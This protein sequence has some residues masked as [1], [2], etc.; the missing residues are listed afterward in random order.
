[1]LRA[2]SDAASTPE[3][4]AR[5]LNQVA[6]LRLAGWA[7][8][9][10]RLAVTAA[11]CS[12]RMSRRRVVRPTRPLPPCRHLRFVSHRRCRVGAGRLWLSALNLNEAEEQAL[13]CRAAQLESLAAGRAQDG[14]VGGEAERAT[15]RRRE[16]AADWRVRLLRQTGR[17]VTKKND[18]ERTNGVTDGRQKAL[19][20]S[21]VLSRLHSFD[22]NPRWLMLPSPSPVLLFCFSSF[23]LAWH[24]CSV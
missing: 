6:W 20:N 16:A 4:R 19:I 13:A 8:G 17:Q 3:T 12:C 10:P 14:P 7:A 15:E 22:V 2:C 23:S 11:R 5:A 1:M 18:Q 9:R 24:R 21:Q